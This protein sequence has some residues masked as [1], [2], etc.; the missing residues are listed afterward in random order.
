MLAILLILGLGG[1]FSLFKTET[2]AHSVTDESQ[3]IAKTLK[4]FPEVEF[5]YNTATGK[6]FLLG[7]VMTEIDQQEMVYLLKSLSFVNS[8]EDNVIID[9]LVWEN[10]NALMMKMPHGAA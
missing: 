6:L 10:I 5:S 3:D 9:E 1:V 4:Q 2:V 7:H 8:I